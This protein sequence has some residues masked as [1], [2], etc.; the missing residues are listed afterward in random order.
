MT[1]S[2]SRKCLFLDKNTL[3]TALAG[4]RGNLRPGRSSK[5][6][7]VSKPY[8]NLAQSSARL[9]EL[10]IVQQTYRQRNARFL[11]SAASRLC[12]RKPSVC[13]RWNHIRSRPISAHDQLVIIRIGTSFSS[14]IPQ[15]ISAHAQELSGLQYD[16][17]AAL[18]LQV[19]TVFVL[20]SFR[21]ATTD[22]LY[23][24]DAVGP[25]S[26]QSNIKPNARKCISGF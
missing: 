12:T 4:L 3:N 6:F 5:V 8:W 7:F 9:S 24:Y 18:R 19:S 21:Y 2:S 22:W 25:P 14:R 16:F 13:S 20:G 15:D 10:D 26:F 17:Y 1:G 11:L 23:S